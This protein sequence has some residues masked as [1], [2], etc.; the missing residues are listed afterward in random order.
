M[1]FFVMNT[2]YD[3]SHPQVELSKY[4]LARF[5]DKLEKSLPGS[6]HMNGELNGLAYQNK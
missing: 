2:S 3:V 4:E 6:A 1:Q 5:S